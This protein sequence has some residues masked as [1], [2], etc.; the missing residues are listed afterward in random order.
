MHKFSLFIGIDVS[1]AWLDMAI[2]SHENQLQQT[3]RIENS[4]DAIT[5]YVQALS[6]QTHPLQIKRSQGM[7]RGKTDQQ[8]DQPRW[9]SGVPRARTLT[10]RMLAGQPQ[11]SG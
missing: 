1:K 3:D 7:T 4:V 2:V 10:W 9:H 5:K 8:D 6:S 11:R